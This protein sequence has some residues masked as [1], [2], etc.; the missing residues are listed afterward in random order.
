MLPRLVLIVLASLFSFAVV[1]AKGVKEQ[2]V[3]LQFSTEQDVAEA[4]AKVPCENR[5]RLAGTRA[6]FESVATAPVDVVVDKH[7]GVDNVLITKKG[8]SDEVVILGAHYD[9]VIEGCG[10]LDNWAGI[11]AVAHAFK[12]LKTA[13][14]QRT[15]VLAAFG[16]EEDGMVG[17]RAMARA[18]PDDRVGL[19]CAMVNVDAVGLGP[20]QVAENMSTPKLTE[21][22]RALAKEL[23]VPFASASVDGANSDSAAFMSR[24]VPSVSVH[25]MD[26]TWSQ[27]LHSNR[28]QLARVKPSSVYLVYRFVLAMIVRLDNAPCGAFR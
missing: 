27:V 28:D 19:H 17:S 12:T 18:I 9:K 22:A 25:S 7:K 16:R 21:F 3:T 11:V 26:N 8:S 5:D 13:P 24:K 14:L 10:A 23:G 2:A 1:T 20:P 4:L 6:L 15:L